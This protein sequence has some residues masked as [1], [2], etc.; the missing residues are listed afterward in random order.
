MAL[1]RDL[2]PHSPFVQT[3]RSTGDRHPFFDDQQLSPI[4]SP[5]FRREYYSPGTARPSSARSINSSLR[6]A[7][8]DRPPSYLSE[9]LDFD[10]RSQFDSHFD[11]RARLVGRRESEFILRMDEEVKR[12]SEKDSL[13]K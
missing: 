11:E 12:Q 9:R 10:E 1:Q 7:T 8:L 4:S 5:G 13:L 2:D 6:S 3:P